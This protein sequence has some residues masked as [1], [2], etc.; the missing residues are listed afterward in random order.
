MR[1]KS[2]WNF[3]LGGDYKFFLMIMG[4][5]SATA[6]YAC[7][8]CEIHKQFRWDTSKDLLFY[9]KE[10]L[11]RIMDRI[12]DLCQCKSSNFGCINLPLINIDLDHVVPEELHL[13][14]RVTDRTLE[15]V[16]DEML[17]KNAIED[18]NRPRGQPKGA[19]LKK[20]VEDV[21]E[22][23]ITFSMWYKKNADGSSSKVLEFPSLVG[24]QK[25]LLLKNMPASCTITYTLKLLPLLP[26]SGMI[27]RNTMIL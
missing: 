13:L 20:F 1:K 6:D 21:N 16:V 4:L 18:F 11:K 9:N 23:G 25:K 3:F 19:L 12:K 8:W 2:S 14:L 22:L 17:E 7:L 27:S 15:N 24:A 26:K 10:P 5:N